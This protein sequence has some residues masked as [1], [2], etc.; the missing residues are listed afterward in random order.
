MNIAKF[1]KLEEVVNEFNM[2]WDEAT[3]AEQT[4][5]E[6]IAAV[7]ARIEND[8]NTTA[9]RVAYLQSKIK[10]MRNSETV[11]RVANMELKAIESKSYGITAE[12]REAIE[13]EI[14]KGRAAMVDARKIK[15]REAL[16]EAEEEIKVARKE[17]L[18]R[19]FVL[20]ERGIESRENELLKMQE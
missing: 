10:D 13:T 3:R 16:Q 2:C 6:I 11:R 15:V 5:R 20:L 4:A 18:G 17:C 8:K 7:Q 9:E 14:N 19:D 1:K 12:E